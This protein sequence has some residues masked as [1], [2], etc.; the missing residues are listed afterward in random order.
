VETVV[1]LLNSIDVYTPSGVRSFELWNGDITGLG[2]AVDLLIISSVER[3]FHPVKNTVIGALSQTLGISGEQ[4]S[5]NPELQFA[6]PS[7]RLWISGTIDPNRIGR[8]M[9]VEI[10]FRAISPAQIVQ[11]AFRILPVLEARGLALGTICLP[12][13]GAGLHALTADSVLPAILEGAQW[14]LHVLKSVE[15]ICFVEI[16]SGRA[17][18]M[19]NA[20]DDVL[21]RVRGSL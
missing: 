9:C 2:F 1:E 20:M 13:L 15:R 19:S 6:Q 4:L 18:V 5:K 11:Q 10:P 17:I 3:G 12:V 21:G 14:A 8:I 7:S 16:N